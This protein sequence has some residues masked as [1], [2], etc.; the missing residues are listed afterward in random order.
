MYPYFAMKVAGVHVPG[1]VAKFITSCQFIQM[2]ICMVVNTVSTYYYGNG[3]TFFHT[4]PHQKYIIKLT[5]SLQ[6]LE[7]LTAVEAHTA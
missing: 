4:N 2:L 7:L 6:F 5:H 1:F 3:V